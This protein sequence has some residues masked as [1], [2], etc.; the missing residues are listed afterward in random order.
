MGTVDA[1]RFI[2]RSTSGLPDNVAPSV[3]SLYLV[4]PDRVMGVS[5]PPA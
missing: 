1:L 4:I 2:V 5:A 3:L